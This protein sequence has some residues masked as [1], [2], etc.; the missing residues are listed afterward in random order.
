MPR[1]IPVPFWFLA[2]AIP[3]AC[4]VTIIA[5]QAGLLWPDSTGQAMLVGCAVVGVA[6]SALGQ[7]FPRALLVLW[8]V[9]G[10]LAA[11]ATWRSLAL[12]LPPTSAW[13]ALEWLMIPAAATV[14]VGVGSRP[15]L[16]DDPAIR[17]EWMMD[18]WT[19]DKW[20]MVVAGVLSACLAMT[21]LQ[22]D[23]LYRSIYLAGWPNINVAVN[24][25]A[26]FFAGSL[27]AIAAGRTPSRLRWAILSLGI[28]SLLAITVLT[29]RRT[30]LALGLVTLALM[31]LAARH[32][33]GF[34]PPRFWLPPM[35]F[36]AFGVLAL[37]AWWMS[38]AAV[39]GTGQRLRLYQ[40]GLECIA[41][42]GVL[43]GGFHPAA[44][45]QD[46]T[47]E[48]ARHL[49]MG[50]MWGLHLHSEP[51]EVIATAGAVGAGALVA[52][53]V[54][55]CWIVRSIADRP[56]RWACG[57]TLALLGIV[58]LIDPSLSTLQGAWMAGIA[59][60][61]AIRAMPVHLASAPRWPGWIAAALAASVFAACLQGLSPVIEL[62]S[63]S[64]SRDL[65]LGVEHVQEREVGTLETERQARVLLTNG[66][67]AGVG[68]LLDLAAQ[69]FGWNG[70]LPILRAAAADATGT[71]AEIRLAH[72]RILRRNPLNLASAAALVRLDQRDPTEYGR[73]APHILY[74]ALLVLS[75]PRITPGAPPFPVDD[76]T[77]G[78]LALESLLWHWQR[79]G[80]SPALDQT[81]SAVVTRYG[82]IPDVA[83]LTAQLSLT[84]SRIGPWLEQNAAILRAG[85]RARDGVAQA[86]ARITNGPSAMHAKRVL[87]VLT[88]DLQAGWATAA[89][90]SYEAE[91]W[92]V[93]QLAN[94]TP[95]PAGLQ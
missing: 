36:G 51:L 49:T 88:P 53:I 16:A 21:W 12:G 84:D 71:P 48:W 87:M 76:I 90:G 58:A 37:G 52:G 95:S 60:G 32:R 6:F 65:A 29:G 8:S 57:T 38:D 91:A 50:G 34:P 5:K 25:C 73:I 9:V 61:F 81:L 42:G 78:M 80:W 28:L 14:V 26:P 35:L 46:L 39:V 56:T 19:M 89:A 18:K 86:L 10:L 79:T 41:A 59:I 77:S 43:G 27:A 31:A 92:R 24:T 68:P 74:G 1:R 64:S 40:V 7:T 85:F 20:T 69:R 94:S 30:V 54:L 17:D 15:E 70:Y 72:E 75:D 2:L 62:R 45:A 66:K 3:T 23:L 82:D 44:W 83:A 93:V 55:L 4:F 33:P 22:G 63:T 67:A 13:R 11:Y 47:S